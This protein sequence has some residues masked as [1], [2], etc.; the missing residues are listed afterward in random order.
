M[1][2][3]VSY[4]KQEK[5]HDQLAIERAQSM[6]QVFRHC[7]LLDFPVNSDWSLQV[8][9]PGPVSPKVMFKKSSPDDAPTIEIERYDADPIIDKGVKTDTGNWGGHEYLSIISP[10]FFHVIV[11]NFN[12]FLPGY[13][14]SFTGHNQTSQQRKQTVDF[15]A[16]FVANTKPIKGTRKWE[17]LGISLK[18]VG[19]ANLQTGDAKVVFEAKKDSVK[20]EANCFV[21]VR[22]IEELKQTSN[23]KSI[24]CL[25]LICTIAKDAVAV[26]RSVTVPLSKEAPEWKC[27]SSQKLG[28]WKVIVNHI[29]DDFGERAHA[30]H[31]LLGT[32]LLD[33]SLHN[34]GDGFYWNGIP[35]KVNLPSLEQMTSS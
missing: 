30:I 4:A 11:K 10:H 8:I 12:T 3:P 34:E 24:L 6:E 14:V 16:W 19:F 22:S 13:R 31:E 21:A 29:P 7:L 33:Q 32:P 5:N 26:F 15:M 9:E 25:K 1:A 2:N 28:K 17:A 20:I 35:V 23:N 27:A 18:K